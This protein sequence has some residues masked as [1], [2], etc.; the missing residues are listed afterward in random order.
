MIVIEY[1]NKRPLVILRDSKNGNSRN[2][3]VTAG[4]SDDDTSVEG[5]SCKTARSQNRDDVDPDD[6]SDV[7]SFANDRIGVAKHDF[8]LYHWKITTDKG[9]NTG[10]R[11]IVNPTKL[12]K[13][14]LKF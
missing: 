3:D 12:E 7:L 10:I 8:E 4:E 2:E 11:S 13:I 6:S 5:R 9:N 1:S 14:N